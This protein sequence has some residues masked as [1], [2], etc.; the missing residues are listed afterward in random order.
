MGYGQDMIKYMFYLRNVL[1]KSYFV[2]WIIGT[3]IFVYVCY[4]QFCRIFGNKMPLDGRSVYITGGSQGVGKALAI[5][6]TS[7]GAHVSIVARNKNILKEALKEMEKTQNVRC[8]SNQKLKAI[9][10]DLT[11]AKEAKRAL[12]EAFETSPDIVFCCVG[13]AQPGFFVDLSPEQIEEG[14]KVNYLTAAYTAHAALRKMINN[15]L[16]SKASPRRIIFCSSLLAFL[17]MAG[18]SQYSP[19]KAA[20]RCL[21]DTLRQEC[22]LYDVKVHCAFLATVY[23]PGFEKEQLIKPELTKEL[24][25]IDQG[26][27]PEIVAL[28]IIK[29]LEKGQFF[30]TTEIIGALLK[31]NMRGPS[32]RDNMVVDTI[33]GYIASFIY[34]FVRISH[35]QIVRKYAKKNRHI[36]K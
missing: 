30:I 8:N 22:L 4:E 15:P 28:H 26:Q 13:A 33:L 35:D 24:E 18:Y 10:A 23:T 11:I 32:P 6:C 7:K 25:G 16:L 12:D 20:L 21:T 2:A 27:L 36:K 1:N 19:S 29:S 34:P 3:L 5:L 9:S 17:G 14:I 31:N